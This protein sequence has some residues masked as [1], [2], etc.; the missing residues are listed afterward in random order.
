MMVAAI[1]TQRMTGNSKLTAGVVSG[2][3]SITAYDIARDEEWFNN[4]NVVQQGGFI[5][6]YGVAEGAPAFV[7]AKIFDRFKALRANSKGAADFI[8]GALMN[9]LSPWVKRR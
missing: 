1:V 3:G 7:G 2:M 6:G 4:M 5:L 8:Y 9:T